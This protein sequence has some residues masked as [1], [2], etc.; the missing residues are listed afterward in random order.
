MLIPL[1]KFFLLVLTKLDGMVFDDIMSWGI[2]FYLH[3]L[4]RQLENGACV[5]QLYTV[6]H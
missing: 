3:G 1:K 5:W 2:F 6:S 4:C